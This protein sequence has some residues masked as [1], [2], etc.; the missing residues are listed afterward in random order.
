VLILPFIYWHV[1]VK[2]WFTGPI[3]QVTTVAE[4]LDPSNATLADNVSRIVSV[5]RYPGRMSAEA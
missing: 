4:E 2:K 1:S 3:K 5:S